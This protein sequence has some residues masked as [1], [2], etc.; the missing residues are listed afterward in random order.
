MTFQAGLPTVPAIGTQPPAMT[1]ADKALLLTIA[2]ALR[3][4]L[5]APPRPYGPEH[6]PRRRMPLALRR[7]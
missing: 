2:G 5:L 3:T 1:E 6:L 4:N 7:T